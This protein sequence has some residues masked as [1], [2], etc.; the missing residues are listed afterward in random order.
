MG[1][2]TQETLS[3]LSQDV[4]DLKTAVDTAESVTPH[5]FAEIYRM[6]KEMKTALDVAGDKL[7]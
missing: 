5:E 3:W 6:I 1:V 4:R 7:G 2:L